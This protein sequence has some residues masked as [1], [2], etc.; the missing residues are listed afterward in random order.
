[1][2]NLL[3][4]LLALA[5]ATALSVSAFAAPARPNV[6]VFF[7]DDV[8][9][10]D[11]R[12][13]GA[14]DARTPNLDRFARQGVR[15][16]QCYAAAPVCT[17]TRAA[18]MTGRY[19]HRIGLEEVIAPSRRNA[20]QGLPSSEPSLPRMMHDAGY[21]TGLFG[22]WHLGA[23]PEFHP[24][25]HGFDEFF[26]FLGGAINYYSHLG[27]DGKH[28]LYANDKPVELKGY[29]TDEITARTVSFIERHKDEPFFVDVAYNATH[30]PFHP[31][32][33]DAAPAHPH[34]TPADVLRAWSGE[35]TREDYVKMLERADE[36]IGRILATL[37]RLGLRENTLVIFTS[38][39]G[40]EWLS[41]MGP[42]SQRKRSLWEGGL[43]V[44]CILRWPA[45]LPG[46]HVSSQPAITMDLTATILAAAKV[47]PSRSRP[48][49]GISLLPLLQ[50]NARRVERTFFW[51]GP[52]AGTN[53]RAMREGRWKYISDSPLFPGMLFDVEADPG[54]RKELAAKHPDVLK[55]LRDLHAAWESSLRPAKD[56]AV[57]N[58]ELPAKGK[59]NGID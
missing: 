34:G 58:P 48:L 30:W 20:N 33:L 6:V 45:N 56:A 43:R 14:T 17:P 55:R 44:P 40:G 57:Q 10:A 54:E 23:L 28:D 52:N 21:A 35:G 36:G 5:S 12:I 53:D 38:D 46:G 9:Y 50:K 31:P 47:E 25:R 37:D 4:R 19:Q 29:L 11:L 18:F 24:N 49:D 26:G 42:L 51:L 16:T 13:D 7:M 32:D 1:M 22:K 2:T 41:H 15:L 59:A 39:N 27:E 3:M 8:G